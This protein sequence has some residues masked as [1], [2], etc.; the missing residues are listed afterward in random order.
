M[1]RYAVRLGGRAEQDLRDLY[2]YLSV[3]ASPAIAR[4]YVD[5]ITAFLTGFQQFP[6]RGSLYPELRKGLRIVGFERRVSIAFVVE[7]SEVL[8]LRLLYGGRSFDPDD[9]E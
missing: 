3:E 1:K 8:V 4:R 5:R 2:N 9:L 7:E 6:S